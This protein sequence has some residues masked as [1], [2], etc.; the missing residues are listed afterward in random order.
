MA[1]TSNWRGCSD[2]KM[3]YYNEWADP[4]LIAEI[5]GKTYTFNYWD[6]ED[7]LWDMF[8][9][10]NGISERDTYDANKNISS[11]WEDKFSKYCQD[12]AYDYL[13]E[14]VYSGYFDGIEDEDGA[15]WHSRYEGCYPKKKSK[16]ILN[17]KCGSKEGCSTKRKINT[18]SLKARTS[19]GKVFDNQDDAVIH[20]SVLGTGKIDYSLD[21]GE[22]W[23]YE[24]GYPSGKGGWHRRSKKEGINAGVPN[25]GK[26]K[27]YELVDYFD[28]WGNAEDGW[29]VNNQ[30]VWDDADDI[31]MSDDTTDT[32]LIDYLKGI[33]YLNDNVK[34]SD[35]YIDW[36]DGDFIEIFKADDMMPICSLRVNEYSRR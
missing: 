5:D 23:D 8:L 18:S 32:E 27:F 10:D 35:L 16:K 20:Q 25:G 7:A 3:K 22:T 14:C 29:E 15:S 2:I 6:I 1:K 9:E 36:G 19:D 12:Y 34:E 13:E 24:F 33:R 11:E 4:D 26:G 30:S 31:Y 21:D 17:Q 28:V